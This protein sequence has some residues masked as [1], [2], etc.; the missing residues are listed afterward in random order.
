MPEKNQSVKFTLNYDG[1][2]SILELGEAVE[3]VKSVYET[4][5]S[6][7]PGTVDDEEAIQVFSF[8]NEKWYINFVS[9]DVV[10]EITSAKWEKD[11]KISIS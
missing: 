11:I 7:Y 10:Y 6:A 1:R 9:E 8:K 5:Y 2:S 4:G 3:D